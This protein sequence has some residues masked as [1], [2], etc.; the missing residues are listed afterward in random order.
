MIKY[1]LLFV[2]LLTLLST[3]SFSQGVAINT[4]NTDADASSMLDVKS[5]NKG[6][7]IP[8]MTTAQRNAIATP[9]EGLLVYDT[10]TDSF[11]FFSGTW[12][13]LGA[14]GADA[15]FFVQGSTNNPSSIT[16]NIYTR[17]NMV[18][19][20]NLSSTMDLVV[21]GAEPTFKIGSN[22]GSFNNVESGRLVFEENVPLYTTNPTSYCGFAFEHEGLINNL[23]L[24]TACVAP[25]TIMTFERNGDVGIGTEDPTA[26]LSVNGTADKT[27]GGTWA[28]FSDRRLKKDIIPYTD[29]L[30]KILA[31]NPVKFK[32]IKEF[33]IKDDLEKEFVGVIAQDIQQIAPYM[34]EEVVYKSDKKNPN[35]A[36]YKEGSTTSKDNS[37]LTGENILSYDASALNYMLINAVKEQQ[38]IIE[39]QATKIEALESEVKALKTLQEE[40]NKIKKQLAEKE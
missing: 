17:G 4:D 14:G 21:T 24:R 25:S 9:A 3:Q 27:G 1:N 19:G 30:S 34:V 38:A 8:R 32:Y 11:W 7:L 33:A 39:Q 26:T 12:T 6:V 2:L 20:D 22:L 10:T 40:I 35:D 13:Q 29:G 36:D 23:Y 37:G 28:A 15:D 5:T 18:V 16:D 31:I